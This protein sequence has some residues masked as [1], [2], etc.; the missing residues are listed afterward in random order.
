MIGK[1][2]IT[3][4]TPTFNRAYTLERLYRSLKSQT[5]KDFEWILID[6]G[7]T[8]NTELLLNQ[9]KKETWEF[10]IIYKKIKN[11]GK[12][13]A[14]NK[15]VQMACGEAFFIVDSD[16][17]LV[18]DA[19]AFIKNEFGKVV[20]DKRFA[21]ISGMKC[22]CIDNSMIGGIP[23]FTEYV[24]ATNLERGK[25]NLLGDKA[26]I[27]KTELLRKYPF[28]EF[29]GENFLTEAVV[30]NSIA[31]DGYIIRWFTKRLY[32]CE[33]LE[34]GLSKNSFMVFQKNPLG[35]AEYIKRE[36][37]YEGKEIIY[38]HTYQF[39]ECMH[40]YYT[41]D[42]LV[43]LLE[44]DKNEY[45][46]LCEI[47]RSVLEQVKKK[48]EQ[49]STLALYGIGNNAR[50]LQLYLKEANIKVFYYIDRDQKPKK[51]AV[52]IYSIDMELPLVDSICITSNKITEEWEYL[53]KKKMP[54][55]IIWRIGELDETIWE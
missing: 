15:G 18:E 32:Y 47:W 20:K 53:I 21:G 25:H 10:P 42:K 5:C 52:P 11:G 3:V 6:D 30:W 28:P 50:R 12:H 13:R 23:N 39:F 37:Y 43:Q 46:K 45:I 24:D 29:E 27:Y 55:S 14:V 1:N 33:Y 44:L 31:V 48:T 38:K 9:W 19:I 8:D 35:W 2:M 26:E 54:D 17:Y 7:S 22:S 16:D 4:F 34:D 51:D 40:F 41:E 36:K 49:I